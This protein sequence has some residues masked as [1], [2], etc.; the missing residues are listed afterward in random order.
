MPKSDH[1]RRA[2]GSAGLVSEFENDECSENI[3]SGLKQALEA[4]KKLGRPRVDIDRSHVEELRASGASWRTI[5]EKLVVGLGTAHRIV[6]SR[7]KNVK[8]LQ[9]FATKT[10]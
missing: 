3:K 5:A 4:G 1:A 6:Q 7:S 9:D 10:E 8:G 2:L